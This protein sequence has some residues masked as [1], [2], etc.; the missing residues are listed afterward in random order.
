MGARCGND[1]ST[2]TRDIRVEDT[3]QMTRGAGD[4]RQR[5]PRVLAIA[6]ACNPTLGSEPGAAWGVVM[7]IAEVADV[8]VLVRTDHMPDITR[9]LED[10]PDDRLDF[11]AV[12]TPPSRVLDP[13]IGLHR[14]FWFV[15]Y[16]RWLKRAEKVGNELQAQLP[17]DAA[18]HVAYGSYWLPSPVVDFG[19]PSVWGP[20]GG[21]TTTPKQLRPLLG[22]KGMLGEYEGRLAIAV[23]SRLPSTRRTWREAT[24][25]I[26][27]TE[28]T[29]AALPAD[30]RADTRVIN[31][32][33]LSKVPSATA[34][35][36]Q[37]Y[38]V[39]PSSLQ[40][41]KGPRLAVMAL[42]HTP[43]HVRLKFVADGYEEGTLRSLAAEL[44]VA[45]RVDFLGRVPRDDMFRMMQESAAVVFTGLREEGGCALSESMLVGAPVIVLGYAGPRLIAETNTDESRVAI[46]EPR[47][48]EE[49]A[50]DL[51]AAMTRF[52][53]EISDRTGGYLDQVSVEKAL[54]EAVL[55]AIATGS[56]RA[57]SDG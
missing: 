52:T 11:V 23:C 6:F 48:P 32:A 34:M 41:R 56:S 13:L 8:T 46:I 17:F 44:G 20:V 40:A 49:T 28:Q 47:T 16:L 5:R 30:L 54:N 27:E 42:A 38:L 15:K 36:R 57:P 2:S 18:I 22:W 29:R 31:R 21:A 35:E 14:Q 19:I 9:W 39:F 43:D 33:I 1:T 53:T 7:A 26:S 51:G 3:E 37:P 24:I 12:E 45:D 25:R 10:N 4:H 50:R 55:D